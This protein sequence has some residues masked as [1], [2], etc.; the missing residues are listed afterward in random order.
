MSQ[1]EQS[2]REFY[3]TYGWS[4]GGEDERFRQF[5]PA[6]RPYH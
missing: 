6:Y 5:R 3:D 2:V 1:V 4:K